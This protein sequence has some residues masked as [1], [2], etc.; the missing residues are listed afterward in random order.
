[1]DARS[2]AREI[3]I[4]RARDDS[5]MIRLLAMQPKAVATIERQDD[6]SFEASE[7]Q[8]LRIGN[9]LPGALEVSQGRHVVATG[10]QR[11]HHRQRKVLVGEQPCH[12]SGCL[13]FRD[14][15][16]DLLS[17]SA[18]VRS[19]IRQVLGAQGRIRAQ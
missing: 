7:R 16:R 17:V 2:L 14:L 8:D 11:F 18:H 19:G 12:G 15:A 1:M 3:Q 10:F 5:R 9:S 6:S 13:V 4:E